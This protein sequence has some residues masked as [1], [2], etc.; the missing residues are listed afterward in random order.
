[1]TTAVAALV[2]VAL[3]DWR[4]NR[5]EIRTDIENRRSRALAE[6]LGFQYEGVLRQAYWVGDR[7][8]DDA[9]YSMLA[10]ERPAGGARLD[11]KLMGAP[12]HRDDE[13]WVCH[14]GMVPYADAL[15][16]QGELRGRR[17]RGE[18][19]DTLLMLEHPP[20][21]TRG[22]RACA[23]ELPF[24]DDFYRGAGHRGTRHRPRRAHHL[25]R[26]RPAR[27]LPDHGDRRRRLATCARWRARSWTRSRRRACERGRGHEDGPD[28]TGVWIGGAQDRL[29]RR[30]RAARRGDARLRG[31]RRQRPRAVQLGGGVRPA[32]RHD[33]LD[34][35]R[36]R[37]RAAAA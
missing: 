20:V 9:V 30:P 4:L 28:Y 24:G 29:D 2:D 22:R 27:R 14:L 23:D 35:A 15:E 21:Y 6:R 32:R 8:S 17:Q 26:P 18:V 13:L 33:D 16:L 19:P 25:P 37:E 10:A 34:R 12:R 7:Y 3:G 5:V 11:C 31:Q 36:A 1:M